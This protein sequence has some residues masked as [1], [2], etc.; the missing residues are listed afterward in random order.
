MPDHPELPTEI[1]AIPAEDNSALQTTVPDVLPDAPDV[2][3]D[4][5]IRPPHP[6]F[7]WAVLWCFG[8][9]VVTQ[10]IPTVIGIVVLLVLLAGKLPPAELGN[11]QVLNNT[12]EYAYAML[13]AMFLSQ[14]LMIGCAWLVI[15]LIVGKEWPRIL[16]V[17]WP[18]WSHAL[19]VLIGLL[20]LIVVSTGIEGIVK[21]TVPSLFD[22]DEMMNLFGRW[23][24]G[25]GILIIGLGPGIGEELWFR[26]FFGRGLVSRYGVVGGILL[27]SLLFGMLHMEPRQAIPAAVM[28]LF[29]HFSYLVSRSLL[30]PMF[31]HTVN[32]SLSILA[33]HSPAL[34]ALNLPADEVPF[35]VYGA[36]LLLL[37]AVGWAMYS[38]R[39]LLMDQKESG[40]AP[41]RP[42]FPGV[43]Y[44]PTGTATTVR[45][46]G[47]NVV[48][49]SL[50]VVCTTLF[51]AAV[52]PVVIAVTK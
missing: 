47:P 29:L 24:V 32:N 17:R 42:A 16:A 4:P 12:P 3:A 8:I 27:T 11:P 30:V 5:P 34:V 10:G 43:A 51:A 44:P 15:R 36:A 37:A 38:S 46:R 14:V 25:L 33:L 52:A 18:H 31:L 7:W 39:A 41:W 21:K 35:Q 2:V 13:L 20:G 49:W 19:L 23:P 1:S 50:V 28:G 6:G 26:G 9:L 48:A 40:A 45:K 22:L